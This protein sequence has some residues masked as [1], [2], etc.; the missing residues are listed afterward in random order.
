MTKIRQ[1]TLAETFS[2]RSQVLDRSIPGDFRHFALR[3]AHPFRQA[4]LNAWAKAGAPDALPI[5]SR[6]PVKVRHA[7]RI[8]TGTGLCPQLDCTV[9]PVI[10]QMTKFPGVSARPSKLFPE[11]SICYD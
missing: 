11:K 9:N 3:R 10:I 6:T 8:V 1:L 4:M 7:W 2:R 5:L